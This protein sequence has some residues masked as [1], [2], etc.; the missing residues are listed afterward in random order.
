MVCFDGPFAS[1]R[2]GGDAEFTGGF[3]DLGVGLFR[4]IDIERNLLL[5]GPR[6]AYQK[7]DYPFI[8][9]ISFCKLSRDSIFLNGNDGY[10]E[11]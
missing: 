9:W 11:I 6:G 7:E 2:C 1:G 5:R 8:G 10:N 4:G 3:P